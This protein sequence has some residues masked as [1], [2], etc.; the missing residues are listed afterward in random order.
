MLIEELQ[1]RDK[2]LNVL[3]DTHQKQGSALETAQNKL[4]NVENRCAQQEDD[5]ELMAQRLTSLT[6]ECMSLEKEN[7]HLK[8]CLCEAE[9]RNKE[10]V[11]T[12]DGLRK[13]IDELETKNASLCLSLKDSSL[14]IGTLQGKEQE[15]VTQLRLKDQE[16]IDAT[17]KI[18]EV[19]AKNDKAEVQL[20]ES[21]AAENELHKK[22]CEWKSKHG[23]V[24]RDLQKLS[25][26]YASLIETHKELCMAFDKCKETLSKS[27]R[28][29]E[30]STEREKRKDQLLE[31]QKS[32]QDRA[33]TE[34]KN[35]KTTFEQTQREL[36]SLQVN[37]QTARQV[38]AEESRRKEW[39]R[40]P[41]PIECTCNLQCT[42][43]PDDFNNNNY[44]QPFSA[45]P[46]MGNQSPYTQ[47]GNTYGN[48]PP[49]HNQYG[50]GY[51]NQP[52]TQSN[53]YGNTYGNACYDQEK[54][55]NA[56]LKYGKSSQQ[57]AYIM[58]PPAKPNDY[59]VQSP[60]RISTK[61]NMDNQHMDSTHIEPQQQ[62]TPRGERTK[63]NDDPKI[64]ERD[65]PKQTKRER[66]TFKGNSY[67]SLPRN[68]M[69]DLDQEPTR[70][71]DDRNIKYANSPRYS[72]PSPHP[73]QGKIKD[74]RYHKRASHDDIQGRDN[75]SDIEDRK[76]K[77]KTNNNQTMRHDG[78]H[79]D[80]YGRD[81]GN[82]RNDGDSANYYK[83]K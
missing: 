13:N 56:W 23:D 50:N 69:S 27:S 9:Q 11:K 40:Q 16:L 66:P 5:L 64:Q 71:N 17:T 14:T 65:E 44:Y 57:P 58:N 52:P 49:Y 53:E 63:R 41:P 32:K 55:Y 68:S 48:Q 15:H 76:P 82:R 83:R 28:D 79:K 25:A 37:L 29:Y 1:D 43:D 6:Q 8:S 77:E 78:H 54:E 22:C 59:Q 61:G 36:A 72:T 70:D 46:Q 51:R 81:K 75:I 73:A 33:E 35:L 74:E 10:L 80:P 24:S 18:S 30:L 2:E 3:L 39:D 62:S 21:R 34:L 45:P 31:L 20:K 26:D 4:M 47:Y 42:C 60:P 67:A 19:S 7:A 38:M 12:N